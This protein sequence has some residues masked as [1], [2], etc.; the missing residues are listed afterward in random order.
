MRSAPQRTAMELAYRELMI[1]LKD[2]GRR[3]GSI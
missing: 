1:L 3:W 2:G